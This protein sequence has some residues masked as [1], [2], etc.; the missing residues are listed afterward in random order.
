MQ[1]IGRCEHFTGIL[2]FCMH[3]SHL[4]QVMTHALEAFYTDWGFDGYDV[5]QLRPSRYGSRGHNATADFIGLKSGASNYLAT[6]HILL[7]QLTKSCSK[8]L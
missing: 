1:I 8:L 7:A 5:L 2:C 6:T 3:K 4:G